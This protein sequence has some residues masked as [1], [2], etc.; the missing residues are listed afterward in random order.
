VSA[1]PDPVR[2]LL[3]HTLATLAYRG[4]KVLREVGDSFPSYQPGEGTRPPL[5]ILAHI[6]DLLDWMRQLCEGR[7]VWNDSVP[8]SWDS[9]VQRFHRTLAEVDGYLASE[10]PLGSS[11]EQLF[12]GPIADALT[13]V[14]QLAL[15]RRRAGRPVRGENYFK[16]DI[17]AGRM[18]PEQNRARVEFD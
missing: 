5:R 15:L 17:V 6:N 3:R 16:A 7:H 10:Q 14:G 8:G 13:H 18:G 12:Q 4:G 9:E 1:P 2:A 11:P